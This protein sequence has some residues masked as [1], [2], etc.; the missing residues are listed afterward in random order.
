MCG[1]ARFW[2]A[3]NGKE[4]CSAATV[5]SSEYHLH[6][7]DLRRLHRRA[8]LQNIHVHILP[9][10]SVLDASAIFQYVSV[11]FVSAPAD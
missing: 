4:L 7:I 11:S 2:M 10:M 3:Q 5:A 8:N 9:L 6:S 1:S